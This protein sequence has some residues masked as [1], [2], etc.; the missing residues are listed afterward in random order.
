MIFSTS[1]RE[2]EISKANDD[3]YFRKSDVVGLIIDSEENDGTIDSRVLLEKLRKLPT[4]PQPKTDED[5]I[6]RK[7]VLKLRKYNLNGGIHTV[8]V[9]DIEKLPIIPKTKTEG[10]LISRKSVIQLTREMISAEEYGLMDLLDE[11]KKLP[12]IPQPKAEEDF[13]SRKAVLEKFCDW[14]C[15]EN[16]CNGDNEQCLSI[17]WIK[18]LPTIPQTDIS[19]SYMVEE[20]AELGKWNELT[21]KEVNMTDIFTRLKEDIENER[22]NVNSDKFTELEKSYNNGYFDGALY[23]IGVFFAH[24]NAYEK[25]TNMAEWIY[26]G[27]DD[28]AI[29]E[30]QCSNCGKYQDDVTNFCPNCGCRMKGENQ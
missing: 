11:V 12:T 7:A 19:H 25:Q 5:L 27:E 15:G 24:N 22:E 17:R 21:V 1:N 6:S 2:V 28:L 14:N 26:C 23:V 30:Y 18:N 9:A 4:I 16:S 3:S 10:D 13:I 29:S 20:K 8:N